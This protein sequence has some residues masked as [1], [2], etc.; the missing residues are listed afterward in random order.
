MIGVYSSK[1]LLL[2]VGCL[3]CHCVLRW[4]PK[5]V[6]QIMY[7]TCILPRYWH[8]LVMKGAAKPRVCGIHCKGENVL[9]YIMDLP[10]PKLYRL[11]SV[12]KIKLFKNLYQ[13]SLLPNVITHLLCLKGVASE[14]A[15]KIEDAASYWIALSLVSINMIIHH[16]PSTSFPKTIKAL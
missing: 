5:L 14:T 10:S 2:M 8:K 6:N 13:I 9:N 7:W 16:I 15:T 12:S 3:S 1:C 11:I 4:L